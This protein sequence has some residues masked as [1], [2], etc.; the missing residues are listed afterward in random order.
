MWCVSA[1]ELMMLPADMVIARDPAFRKYAEVRVAAAAAVAVAAAAVAAAAFSDRCC[2][3]ACG[4]NLMAAQLYALDATKFAEDFAKAFRKLQELGV[5]AA[6]GAAPKVAV[7]PSMVAQVTAAA[8]A[9]VANMA[10][11]ASA[12][13]VTKALDKAWWAFWK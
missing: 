13:A 9:K 7:A 12:P 2:C 6:A 1:G 8:K 5:P 10:A 11:P 3:C 4:A